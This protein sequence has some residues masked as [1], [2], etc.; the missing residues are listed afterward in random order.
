MRR[1]SGCSRRST[2]DA[3]SPKSPANPIGPTGIVPAGCSSG[4]GGTT[5]WFS[6]RPAG[7][8]WHGACSGH[9]AIPETVVAGRGHMFRVRVFTPPA[10][11]EEG[12]LEAGGELRLGDQ[13]VGFVVDL[14]HWTVGDYERQWKEGTARL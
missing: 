10:P 5:R 1:T 7:D 3:A 14:S 11:N 13:R 12:L 4:F 9:G 8:P 2:A 6:T